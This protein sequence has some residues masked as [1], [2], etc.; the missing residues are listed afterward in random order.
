MGV[1][2][3]SMRTTMQIRGYSART[4]EVYLSC[5]RVFANHFR[6]SPLLISMKEIESFFHFLRQQNRSD[7]TIHL[8]Y[9]SMKFFYDIN[10]ITDRLPHLT[11]GKIRN[12]V[13]IVLSQ[14][15][16][17]TMLASC[18][19][20]KYK[21]LFT[22]AYASGLRTSELR[23]LEVRDIDF[24]RKQVFV[25]NGKNGRSRYSILGNKTIQLIKTYLNVYR[26]H[27]YLFYNQ[28]DILA[29]VSKD[30][31]RRELGRLLIANGIDAREV[32]LHTLRHCFATHL[33]ENGT[34][35][36]HI[37]H[38]L[39]HVSIFTT[40]VY[41]HMQDLHKLSIKSPIDLLEPRINEETDPR[42]ELFAATA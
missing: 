13:P 20:L 41:L 10:N 34:S 7:S 17:V 24:D 6:R 36:F 28:E 12:K 9:V 42:R 16:V 3:D 39:G 11:F 21:T 26:P 22:L 18:K 32:H 15:K 14:E 5:V 19:S 23:N 27:S 31:I 2:Q 30:A 37:M 33:M 38:L 8:Y 4:V 1:L 29:R 35:I 25:R 40:M